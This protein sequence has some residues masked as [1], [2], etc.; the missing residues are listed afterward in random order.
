MD[1]PLIARLSHG[2]RLEEAD[3]DRLRRL[4]ADARPV[5]ARTDLSFQGDRPDRVH[6]VLDGVAC[7]YRLTEDGGRS[8]MNLV[9]PGDGCDLHVF[10]LRRM[11]HTVATLT[12]CQVVSVP[13]ATLQEVTE[14]HPRI[15]RALWWSTLLDESVLRE[16]LVNMGRRRS[17]R[18]LAHLFCEWHARLRM[19]GRAEERSFP[20]PLTLEELADALGRSAVHVGRSLQ[21]L[22]DQGLVVAQNQVVTIPDLGALRAYAGFDPGYLH[23]GGPE[24]GE[25]RRLA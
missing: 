18:Q 11:D 23:L 20:Q 6:V 4:A 10:V 13:A 1:N 5:P 8:I 3:L 9:L 19:V 16:W 15:A 14:S 21:T 7:R 24:A 2:V 12:E 17:D 22:R 25:P